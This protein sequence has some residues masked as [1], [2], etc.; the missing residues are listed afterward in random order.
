VLQR[1]AKLG[2]KSKRARRTVEADKGETSCNGRLTR[3]W[4]GGAQSTL[5][6]RGYLGAVHKEVKGTWKQNR[7]SEALIV[8]SKHKRA[9]VQSEKTKENLRTTDQGPRKAGFAQKESTL[10]Q[11]A[12]DVGRGKRGVGK[13]W[14]RL[15]ATG[16]QKEQVRFENS[17]GRN[18]NVSP[19]KQRMQ[20][21]SD[22]CAAAGTGKRG[23]TERKHGPGRPI[24]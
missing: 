7:K 19:A 1:P 12:K 22:K 16:K 17:G 5:A 3:A 2:W 8:F 15:G 9:G 4:G 10:F 13:G 24:R 14:E 6:S 23:T 20:E 18:S 21:E 11:F